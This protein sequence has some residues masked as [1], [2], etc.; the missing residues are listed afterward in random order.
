MTIG[1]NS[2]LLS[3][4]GSLPAPSQLAASC[5][6]SQLRSG[7]VEIDKASFS[8]SQNLGDHAEARISAGNV[9]LR[10]AIREEVLLRTVW[11][12]SLCDRFCC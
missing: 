3:K 6:H 1:M 11:Y 7:I 2:I 9:V 8:Q 10:K 12:T 4:F 5:K